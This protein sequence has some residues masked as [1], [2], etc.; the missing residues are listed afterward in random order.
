[1]QPNC[2]V[3]APIRTTS[4]R[5]DQSH[6]R[7]K[8]CSGGSRTSRCVI[9]GVSCI[10]RVDTQCDLSIRFALSTPIG[11]TR[12]AGHGHLRLLRQHMCFPTPNRSVDRRFARQAHAKKTVCSVIDIQAIHS[13]ESWHTGGFSLA[14]RMR[15]SCLPYS[16]HASQQSHGSFCA[17]NLNLVHKQSR[18]HGT[19]FR[20]FE[21][22]VQ[23]CSSSICRSSPS[24]YRPAPATLGRRLRLRR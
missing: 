3:A 18:I 20:R 19:L 16:R 23:Y 21:S 14:A 7:P 22:V 4:P 15:Y 24:S 11:F 1:M 6:I 12:N 17:I 2:G 13:R 10:S 9:F 5:R 8:S